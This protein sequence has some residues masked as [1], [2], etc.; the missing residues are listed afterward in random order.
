MF[1]IVAFLKRFVPFEIKRSTSIISV[2]LT[3]IAI[4]FLSKIGEWLFEEITFLLKLSLPFIG[5]FYSWAISITYQVSLLAIIFYVFAL[6]IL[7]FPIYRKLDKFFMQGRNKELIFKD[8]FSTNQGWQ[9]NYWG[10]TNPAKTNRIEDST[11]IFEASESELQNKNKEFGAYY[12]LKNGIYEG[13][14]YEVRCKVKSDPNT[15]MKFQLW[16][17]DNVIG[18]RSSMRTKKEPE[19]LETPNNEFKEI[20]TH[21]IATATNGIRI[22]LHNKGGFGK[23]YVK[24]ISVYKVS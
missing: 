24:E 4:G 1:K 6:I 19:N 8:D 14:M 20:K 18:N 9:L 16:L 22:H 15:T 10:T 13:Y 17:H 12:D 7:I 2:V 3:L 23:I 11:M 5:N 21:F